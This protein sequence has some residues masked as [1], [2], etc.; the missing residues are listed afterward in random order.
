MPNQIIKNVEE[1][2]KHYLKTD[3]LDKIL[4]GFLDTVNISV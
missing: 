3:T 4:K 1:T 2:K